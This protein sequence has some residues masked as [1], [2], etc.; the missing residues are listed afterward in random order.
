MKR[1]IPL[2]LAVAVASAAA[3]KPPMEHVLV[4]VPLHKQEAE[5][6]LPVT[7]L[8]GDELRR[9]ASS[10]IGDTLNGNP[11]LANASFGPAVGRPVI[12]G[13]QGARV[14]V[15]QNST[16]SA[17]VSGLSADHAVSVEP[18]LAESIEVL[19]GPSTLLYGGGAIGGV[20]NV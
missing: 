12:R 10:T 17:D 16:S 14:M 11:G 5:T 9:I 19:R 6:A 4:T 15:L 18:M 7:V 3:D 1:Y 2:S 8:T 13:Q 20:V